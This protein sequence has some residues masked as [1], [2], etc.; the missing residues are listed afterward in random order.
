MLILN[1][2]KNIPRSR[3]I[4]ALLALKGVSA[5]SIARKLGVDRSLI[6]K[7]IS[8]KTYNKSPRVRAAIAEALD[9]PYEELWGKEE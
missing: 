3:K 6:T 2:Q 5:F 9:V 7:V 4:K 1:E 8:D